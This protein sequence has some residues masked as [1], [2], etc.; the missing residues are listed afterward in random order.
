MGCCVGVPQNSVAIIEQWGR[1]DR[2]ESAGFVRLC[3]CCGE[4]A[5][6]YVSLR[7]QQLAVSCETKTHDNVFVEIVVSVQYRTIAAAAYDA[8]YKLTN[9]REQIRAYVYDVI[10]SG[11]PKITLDTLFESKDDLA[12]S[13]R[14]SLAKVMAGFGYEI[15]QTLVIDIRPSRNVCDAMNEINANM[16]L[17]VAAADK[18]EAE[19]IEIVKNAEA[20]AES[21]Y[22]NGVGI[23][24]QRK[25]IVDGMRDSVIHF[26]QSVPGT[27]AKDVMDLVLVTQYFDTIKDLGHHSKKTTLF[28]PHSPGSVAEVAEEIRGGLMNGLNKTS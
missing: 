5:A 16:R 12:H 14:E 23:A 26:S 24:R 4:S 8:F 19:K 6:G 7:V 2:I 9:P 25:A 20:D 10:R 13:V 15:I 11:V 28:I 1:F 17:R 18:A 21:K 22:L 3:P 27:T